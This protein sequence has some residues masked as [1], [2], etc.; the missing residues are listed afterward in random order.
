MNNLY[1]MHC[2]RNP[3]VTVI[4]LFWMGGGGVS[5]SDPSRDDIVQMM[6]QRRWPDWK[7][8][9]LALAICALLTVVAIIERPFVN[10]KITAESFVWPK[11]CEEK[12]YNDG[13]IIS[14]QCQQDK[15]YIGKGREYGWD[16][17]P[18]GYYRLGNDA[19]QITCKIYDVNSCVVN[20][21]IRNVFVV[22]ENK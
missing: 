22:G 11:G 4:L 13:Q 5:Y 21:I 2:H 12:E 19:I 6:E 14:P 9:V 8:A 3:T 18:G 1:L 17:A 20:R 7:W 10:P 15:Y 16:R